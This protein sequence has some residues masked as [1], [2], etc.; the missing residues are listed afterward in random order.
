M[1]ELFILEQFSAFAK[2][3]TLSEA[4]ESLHLSQPA[5][6]RNMKKL[7]DD[8][9]VSLF[10][11]QKNHMSLNKNGD[12]FYSI[13]HLLLADAKTLE[14]RIRDFDRKSKTISVGLC[15]PAPAWILTPLLSAAY[16]QMTINI[17]CTVRSY[18]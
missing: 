16:P 9:G 10:D 1:I 7:E 11:R 8:L 13:S 17:T 3:G 5:L 4:A 14:D 6:S 2:Y 12:Y 15:A 18:C